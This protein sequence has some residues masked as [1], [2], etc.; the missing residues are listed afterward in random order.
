MKKSLNLTLLFFLFFVLINC[1]IS[2]E[3]FIN[4]EKA[5]KVD[6]LISKYYEKG[7]FNGSVLVAENKDVIF[8]KGY[9]YANMEWDI[10]N[11]SD[12]KFRLGSITKQFTSMLIMQLVEKNRIKL[13]GNLSEYLSYYREDTGNKITIHHLLTHTSGVPSYTSLPNFFQD[14]SKVYYPVKEFIEKYCSGNLEFE[15]GSQYKYSNSG[16]FL[17][18]AVINEVTGKSYED[19]LKENIFEPLNMKDS[20]YDHHD[21]ILKNRAAGYEKTANGYKNAAYLDMALPYSAGALYSTVEDL[22]KWDQA[23]YTNKLLSE[24]NKEKMFKPYLQNYAYGWGVKK[25]DYGQLETLHGGGINGFNTL[26]VRI[27]DD[28]H[29]IVLLNNTGRSQLGEIAK[30]IMA[31][32]Y[33]KPYRLP[34]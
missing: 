23:L 7:I 30:K 3:V 6:A 18:G 17:L 13:D 26:I 11:T 5:K 10:K 9:G 2:E 16:Y 22:Y 25:T 29:L 24:E 12:T 4:G 1:F 33:H 28:K 31:I 34:E 14:I 8:K 32:L 21:T 15:P 27:I 20:G 19:N